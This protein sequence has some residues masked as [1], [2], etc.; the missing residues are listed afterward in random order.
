M[1]AEAKA[2][3]PTV[4]RIFQEHGFLEMCKA[5]QIDDCC[6]GRSTGLGGLLFAAS[7]AMY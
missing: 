6:A 2:I 4:F 7:S 3:G 5:R 1:R